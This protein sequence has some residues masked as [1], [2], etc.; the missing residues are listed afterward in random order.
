MILWLCWIMSFFYKVF[1]DVF[2]RNY[3]ICN[4]LFKWLKIICREKERE[5]NGG[6]QKH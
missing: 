1:A 4:L 2:M 5:S 6:G 3:C